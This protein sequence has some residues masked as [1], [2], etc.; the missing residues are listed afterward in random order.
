MSQ[1]RKGTDP[2]FFK[3][4]R[5]C[6]SDWSPSVWQAALNNSVNSSAPARPQATQ[7]M[8]PV[9]VTHSIASHVWSMPLYSH[10]SSCRGWIYSPPSCPITYSLH[11]D[12]DDN[13]TTC[14]DAILYATTGASGSDRTSTDAWIMDFSLPQYSLY[15]S[16]RSL[17]YPQL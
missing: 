8:A 5:Q 6:Q 11:A 9:V 13:S 3:W 4:S 2:G 14:R 7:K 17:K 12:S 15:L 10:P 1:S 16:E